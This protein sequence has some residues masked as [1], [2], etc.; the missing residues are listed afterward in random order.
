MEKFKKLFLIFLQ[1]L[2][3]GEILLRHGLLAHGEVK[4]GGDSGRGVGDP[5]PPDVTT[6]RR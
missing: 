6:L 1:N 5:R 4:S 3:W 2:P